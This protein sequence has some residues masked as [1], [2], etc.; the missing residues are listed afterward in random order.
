M[1][2]YDADEHSGLAV[3]VNYLT[4]CQTAKRNGDQQF[5]RLGDFLLK[6]RYH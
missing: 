2:R 1:I 4:K 5:K 3:T 6:L